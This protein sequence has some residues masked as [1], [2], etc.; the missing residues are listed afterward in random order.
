MMVRVLSV[1]VVLGMA[2]GGAFA[3]KANNDASGNVVAYI[4]SEANT[5]DIQTRLQTARERASAQGKVNPGTGAV[6]VEFI[7]GT[8]ITFANPAVATIFVGL[9]GDNA[10][11]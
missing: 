4:N 2:S 7:D 5:A 6:T 3:G 9:F 10:R 8:V 11:N 1:A